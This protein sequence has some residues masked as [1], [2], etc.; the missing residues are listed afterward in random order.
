MA[1]R[2]SADRAVA[3]NESEGAVEGL[4]QRLRIPAGLGEDEAA[5]EAG[6]G[7]GGEPGDVGAGPE[8]AGGG[9][10]GEAGADVRFPAVE[11]GG[12]HGADVVVAFPD[13]SQEAGDGA[14]SFPAPL[15]LER[16]Q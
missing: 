14:A 9:H 6:Q 5:L 10:G 13:L 3:G 7:R 12:E 4:A 2:G 11:A 8:L 16:D 15:V 1:L